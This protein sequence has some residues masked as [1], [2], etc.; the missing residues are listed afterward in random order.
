M[1]HYPSPYINKE[2]RTI[3]FYIQNDVAEQISLAGSFNH[4]AQDVLL[5]EPSKDGVWK[6][7]LPMLNDGR[8]L[9]KFFIDSKAWVEDVD[10]PYREPDGFNGFNS[11]LFIQN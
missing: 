9:Y 3:E 11:I 2:K 8:Y 10:N 7:E 4:W 5:F 1:K 6:L